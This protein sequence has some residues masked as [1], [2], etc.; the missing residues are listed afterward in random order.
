M[1]SESS[2]PKLTRAQ[3]EAELSLARSAFKKV[4]DERQELRA[5]GRGAEGELLDDEV[6]RLRRAVDLA[7][8][9]LRGVAPVTAE[10]AGLRLVGDRV[11]GT[12]TVLV[13][14]GTSSAE[15]QRLLDRALGAPLE[16]LAEAHGLA[17]QAAPSRYVRERPGRDEQGRTVLDVS[18]RV[19]GDL[20]VPG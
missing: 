3:L 17:L 20:L 15:R 7:E 14:P 19:E 5:Q 9:A 8:D 12:V 16:E 1:A 11:R 18:A 13:P 6:A 4:R 2:D 10:Q